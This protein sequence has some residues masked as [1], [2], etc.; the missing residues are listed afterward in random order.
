[1][2]PTDPVLPSAEANSLF[3]TEKAQI[4][5]YWKARNTQ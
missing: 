1:M 5:A 4:D 3:A 2:L